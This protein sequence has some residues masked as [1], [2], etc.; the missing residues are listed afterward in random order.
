MGNKEIFK[1]LE[2]KMKRYNDKKIETW[3]KK[4]K[5]AAGKK[6]MEGNVIRSECTRR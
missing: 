4:T 2:R 3:E 1:S 6:A 5:D